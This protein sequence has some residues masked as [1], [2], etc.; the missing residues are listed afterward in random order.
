M[1]YYEVLTTNTAKPIGRTDESYTIF[2][3]Q[4]KQFASLP[5]VSKYLAETY[6][7]CKRQTMF[8]DTKQGIAKQAGWVYCF[9]NNDI[10]HNS[11][12]WYQ[13]DWVE[14]REIKAKTI[15]VGASKQAL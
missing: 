7:D 10:S 9:K 8:I 12:P 2:D 4:K 15:L 5:E 11:K 6:G 13:Q 3:V 1:K 14:V